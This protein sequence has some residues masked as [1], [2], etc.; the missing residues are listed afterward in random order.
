MAQLGSGKSNQPFKTVEDY[1]NF[2]SRAN[3]FAIWCDTAIA[4]MRE[5]ISR[6]I[7]VNHLLVER[8]IP[9]FKD[10]LVSDVKESIFY[11]PI[12]NLPESFSAEEIGLGSF[13]KG[14]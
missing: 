3:S 13:K 2:I 7:T 10:M 8:T 14:E 5:G 11:M 12:T 6:Q 1:N 9:Q 4:N